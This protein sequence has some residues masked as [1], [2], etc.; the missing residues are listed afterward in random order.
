MSSLL[1]LVWTLLALLTCRNGFCFTDPRRSLFDTLR[2]GCEGANCHERKAVSLTFYLLL[3]G[4]IFFFWS[5]L[6]IWHTPS[7]TKNTSYGRVCECLCIV[8]AC[9]YCPKKD[10]MRFLFL[11]TTRVLS[12]SY[13]LTFYYCC[14]GGGRT[15]WCYGQRVHKQR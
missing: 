3:F 8:R 7:F 2:P 12:G 15:F 10:R 4:C 6:G 1:A 13:L 11:N 5:E 9:C 14:E